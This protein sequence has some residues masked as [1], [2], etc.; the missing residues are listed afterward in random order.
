MVYVCFM[1]TISLDVV[2]SIFSYPLSQ[3]PVLFDE[4]GDR[5]GLT[6]IEQ[7]QNKQEVRVGFYDPM[8]KSKNKIQLERSI[9]WISKN[10]CY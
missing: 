6:Q 8:S 5:R 3:G 7:L 1:F 2:I 9:I 4:N 10:F